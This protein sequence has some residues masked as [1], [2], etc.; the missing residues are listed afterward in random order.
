MKGRRKII[1]NKSKGI[2]WLKEIWEVLF[3]ARELFD[4]L[5]K[6]PDAL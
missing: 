1:Q 5:K 4:F 3:Y 6:G 2:L